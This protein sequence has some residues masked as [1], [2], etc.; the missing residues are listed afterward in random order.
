MVKNATVIRKEI[1]LNPDDYVN[2]IGTPTYETNGKMITASCRA[3]VDQDKIAAVFSKHSIAIETTGVATEKKASSD[4]QATQLNDAEKESSTVADNTVAT[5]TT[6]NDQNE[7]DATVAKTQYLDEPL[8]QFLHPAKATASAK[9]NENFKVKLMIAF[10][11]PEEIKKALEA[12]VDPNYISDMNMG[13]SSKL[14]GQLTMKVPLI[15]KYV[16][17]KEAK[18]EIVKMLIN[19]GA[20]YNWENEEGNVSLAQAFLKNGKD[21]MIDY[22]LSLNP[23]LKPLKQLNMWATNADTAKESLLYQWLLHSSKDDKHDLGVFRKLLDL[24][25]DPN[26]LVKEK[27][28]YISYLAFT[29]GGRDFLITLFDHGLDPNLYTSFENSVFEIIVNENDLQLLD[30]YLKQGGSIVNPNDNPSLNYYLFKKRTR[31]DELNRR[32]KNEE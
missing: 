2:L 10:T 8:P 1:L 30:R 13:Y 26:E 9:D 27:N 24:G 3:E 14:K 31:M 19:Y 15:Y 7:P 23:N 6:T 16:A 25:L 20:Y 32:N 22:W 12:G 18:L 21:E 17:W 4:T 5:N 11:K 29:K 28:A